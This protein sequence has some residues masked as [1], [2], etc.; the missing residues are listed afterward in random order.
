MEFKGGIQRVTDKI[1]KYIFQKKGDYE[2]VPVYANEKFG[3]LRAIRYESSLKNILISEEYLN[4]ISFSEGD[5]F[6]GLSSEFRA[7]PLMREY[8]DEMKENGVK[9]LFFLHDILP[10]TNRNWFLY[11]IY[12]SYYNWINEVVRYDGVICNS[13]YTL[14]SFKKWIDNSNYNIKENFTFEYTHLGSDLN[15]VEEYKKIKKNGLNFLMIG[16]V[17]PRKG[18][19]EALKAF[20]KLIEKNQN[21][22]LTIVGKYGWLMNEFMF[23]INENKFFNKNIFW[24]KDL[25]DKELEEIIYESDCLISTSYDEGFGIPTI[26]CAQKGVSLILRNIKIYREIFRED[27]AIFFDDLEKSILMWI[28]LFNKNQHPI[29]NRKF[30]TWSEVSD[31]IYEILLKIK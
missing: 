24:Y 22:R 28:E 19:S 17:E 5:I 26:E 6:L 20:T 9:V 18:Y 16:T 25:N 1:S 27:E 31:K 15:E 13:S 10:I 3:Y 8:L 2:V 4:P 23:E 29:C 21:I 12:K 11:E 14:E 30:N 7:I